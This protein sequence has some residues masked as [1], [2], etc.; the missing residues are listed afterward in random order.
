MHITA[1]C[2]KRNVRIFQ[3]FRLKKRKK[4]KSGVKEGQAKCVGTDQRR[5]SSLCKSWNSCAKAHYT[6]VKPLCIASLK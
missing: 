4:K 5:K 1:F 6:L 2:E 3:S